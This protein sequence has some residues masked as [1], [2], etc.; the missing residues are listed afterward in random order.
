ME[1]MFLASGAASLDE[2][3]ASDLLE[4]ICTVYLQATLGVEELNF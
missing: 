1:A 3:D 2:P 4:T